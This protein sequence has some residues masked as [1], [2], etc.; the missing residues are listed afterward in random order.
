M[1]KNIDKPGELS[2]ILF[3][4]FQRL[5]DLPKEI[6]EKLDTIK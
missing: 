4:R 6:K 2:N 3:S 5:T 1:G